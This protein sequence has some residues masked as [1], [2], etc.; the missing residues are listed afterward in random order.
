MNELVIRSL[1][2]LALIV[3]ALMAAYVG[4]TSFAAIMPAP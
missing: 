2:G 4:G 3:L 1:T